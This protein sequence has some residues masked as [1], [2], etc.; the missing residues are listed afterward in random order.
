M[1]S[2]IRNGV[3][4]STTNLV[5]EGPEICCTAPSNGFLYGGIPSSNV[6]PGDVY[7]FR[8]RGSNSDFNNFLRGT[9]T[10]STKPYIDATIGTDN[11]QWIGATE[12]STATLPATTAGYL[13]EPGEARWYKFRV[14]PGQQAT[15]NLTSLRGLRPRPVRRHR[16]R[17]RPA[18]QRRRPD[19]ARR[20]VSRRRARVGDPDPGLQRRRHHDPD[21]GT[22]PPV[23]TQFAPRIYAPRIYAPRIYAPRIYAPRIYAPRIY[24]PRIYA[25]DS[26]V[27]RPRVQH[28]LPRRLLRRAEPDAARDVRQH[29]PAPETVSAST[30]NTDGYFYVRVQ[31][32]DD[33]VFDAGTPFS[34]TASTSPAARAARAPDLPDRRR[35][36][37]PRATRQHVILTDTNK[38]VLSDGPQAQQT[39]LACSGPWRRAPAESSSTSATSARVQAL[40]DQVGDATRPAR[41]PRTWW[42]AR[43][44]ASSTRYRGDATKYVVIAGGD[45]VIPFFRYPDT[46]GLGQ[47]SQFDAAGPRTPRRRQPDNDQVL[48]QDAYGSDTE[49]TISGAHDARARPRRRAAGED[50]GRDHVDRRPLPRACSGSTLPAPTSSLVT[51]YDFLADAAGARRPASSRRHCPGDRRNDKLITPPGTPTPVLDGDAAGRAAVHRARP[52]LPGRPLQRQRHPGRRL[53]DDVRGRG[54]LDARP[55]PT[56]AKLTDTLVLSAGCHSGY[57]VVDGG[58]A[59]A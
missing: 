45:D 26:F 19:P 48:G 28:L 51:G 9:F 4:I 17:L 56:P 22:K 52:G 34:L 7:G 49:V 42:P 37:G 32:H 12:I 57:N 46:S 27:A 16:Q 33:Q 25:P 39:Y 41:T 58:P 11:R 47:E 35:R 3:E 21:D 36:S 40:Q 55:R 10:L 20:R 6:Q 38:L 30:G 50:A 18:R 24:A 8:L 31:G 5:N 23:T 53:H 2:S 29:R 59:S 15:V 1:P 13:E 44:R 43:S 54:M 14:V